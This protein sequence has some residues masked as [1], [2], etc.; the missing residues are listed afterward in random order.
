VEIR[1]GVNLAKLNGEGFAGIENYVA[2]FPVEK[3]VESAFKD[4]EG[5]GEGEMV[6]AR[7]TRAMGR[8][9][10]LIELSRA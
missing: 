2:V 7:R 8:E 1:E 9:I 3:K 4:G 5:F 6:V 10:D